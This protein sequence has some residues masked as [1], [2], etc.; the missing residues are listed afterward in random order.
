L[1]RPIAIANPLRQINIRFNLLSFTVTQQSTE[2]R[3]VCFSLDT[4]VDVF[5]TAAEV[6]SNPFKVSCEG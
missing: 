2:D 1:K 5:G 3:Q 4:Q 6:G